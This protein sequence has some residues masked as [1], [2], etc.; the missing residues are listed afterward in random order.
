MHQLGSFLDVIQ[1]S[2]AIRRHQ[3]LLH[4]LHDEVQYFL[5]HD[6]LIAAW[7]DF[8][9]GLVHLDVISYLP[10]LRTTEIDKQDLL[11]SL[12]S[13]FEQWM[14]SGRI[15]LEITL[16][17]ASLHFR[18]GE[19]ENSFGKA[20]AL[21]QS[22]LVHGI[23]DQ[24][25][26]H[27]CLYIA[28]SSN[29]HFETTAIQSMEL[30]LPHI[31]TALRQLAHLPTQ[32]PDLQEPTCVECEDDPTQDANMYGL[33]QREFEIMRWVCQGKTNLEIGSILNISSFTVK[34]HLQRIFRKLDV[35]NRAQAVIKLDIAGNSTHG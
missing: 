25:G 8:C 12:L 17:E 27:D 26:R 18:S 15:P 31:D 34:N 32:C 16:N 10:G 35:M 28:L 5:P 33:T 13:M 7:G 4:W 1:D 11:P 29:P 3:D 2:L 20:I 21:M 19:T 9:L 14:E 30:L 24:R 23:K 6:I 22:A